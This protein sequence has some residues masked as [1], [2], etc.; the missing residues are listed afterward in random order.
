MKVMSI[1]EIAEVKILT[2]DR[3]KLMVLK[4]K[5]SKLFLDL[6]ENSSVIDFKENIIYIKRL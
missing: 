3:I 5:W 4:E 6:S 1:S 2:D